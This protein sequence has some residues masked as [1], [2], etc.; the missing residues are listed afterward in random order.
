[1][2]LG[3]CLTQQK[4]LNILAQYKGP[5]C[6]KGIDLCATDISDTGWAVLL[7]SPHFATVENFYARANPFS[8]A[9]ALLLAQKGSSV[10]R[11]SV[12]GGRLGYEGISSLIGMPAIR[13]I[14][15]FRPRLGESE[16]A[17]L[18]QQ[19]QARGVGLLL[20]EPGR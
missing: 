8:D 15:I 1:L 3:L 17:E 12:D 14:F 19:A 16:C 2:P 6:L 13:D 7:D 4:G 11:V 10:K 18:R 5:S 9:T 20:Y